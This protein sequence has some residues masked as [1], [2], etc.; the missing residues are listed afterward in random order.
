MNVVDH[1]SAWF[2]HNLGI[3][4]DV[5][6]HKLKSTRFYFEEPQLVD[7]KKKIMK[8]RCIF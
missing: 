3:D 8:W 5:T 7:R 2:S 1:I 4:L 6:E